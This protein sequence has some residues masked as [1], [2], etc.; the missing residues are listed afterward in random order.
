MCLST[1]PLQKNE[2]A[3]IWEDFLILEQTPTPPPLFADLREVFPWI[4][5]SDVSHLVNLIPRFTVGSQFVG[6]MLVLP[7]PRVFLYRFS[8]P[9]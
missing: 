4:C 2:N 5:D 3:L 7:T 1:R 6:K 9:F 8:T